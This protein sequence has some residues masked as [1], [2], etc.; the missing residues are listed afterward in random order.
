MK[1][2]KIISAAALVGMASVSFNASAA[3][4]NAAEDALAL[5]VAAYQQANSIG[6]AWRDTRKM[7]KK[8]EKLMEAGKFDEAVKQAKAAEM[9]GRLGYEQAHSQASGELHI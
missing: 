2:L 1:A 4:K 7:I 6:G 8:A 3:D 9:Q 5:A